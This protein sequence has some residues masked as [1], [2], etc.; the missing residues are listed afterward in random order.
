[1]REGICLMVWTLDMHIICYTLQNVGF[2]HI[3]FYYSSFMVR[4]WFFL[5][6]FRPFQ[7][8]GWCKEATKI[9]RDLYCFK[10][11]N[12]PCH[13]YSTMTSTLHLSPPPVRRKSTLSEELQAQKALKL[14][15]FL[16]SARRVTL[17]AGNITKLRNG[18]LPFGVICLDDGG[19]WH[20]FR[21]QAM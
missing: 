20:V 7:A 1:M 14:F 6:M 9:I 12:Y 15:S 8:R 19:S 16:A 4:L 13:V 2:L 18:F 5:K 11:D 3:I 17:L 10:L 21:E